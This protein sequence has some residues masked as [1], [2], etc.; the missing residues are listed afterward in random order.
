MQFNLEFSHIGSR[1]LERLLYALDPYESNETIVAQRKLLRTGSPRWVKVNVKDGALS[2]NG[3]LNAKGLT[4][5]L[6]SIKRLNITDL[7]GLDVLDENLKSI[8]NIVELLNI[9]TSDSMRIDA[10]GKKAVFY[11]RENGN[12]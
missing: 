6:P 1:A 2:L 4:I 5:G 7:P 12:N 10:S 9:Y 8:D 11:K 3:E